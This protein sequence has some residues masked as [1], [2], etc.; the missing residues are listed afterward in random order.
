M[1][2]LTKL[3]IIV[4][5]L[6]ALYFGWNYV[7]YPLTGIHLTDVEYLAQQVVLGILVIVAL[8]VVTFLMYFRGGIVVFEED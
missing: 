6:A 2:K 1:G 5:F 4:V 3:L 8:A 7:I